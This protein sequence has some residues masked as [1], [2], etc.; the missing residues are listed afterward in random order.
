VAIEPLAGDHV[1]A[2]WTRLQVLGV[3]A[4]RV[5][6]SSFIAQCQCGSARA[7]QMEEGTREA[8]REVAVVSAAR[9]SRSTGWRTPAAR[10]IT[11]G[12]TCPGSR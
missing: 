8:S 4:S 7:V 3:V 12:W 5:A 6:Y 2:W 11:I 9:I 10:R 1:G